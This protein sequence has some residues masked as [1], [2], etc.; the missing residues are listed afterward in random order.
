M[1][2]NNFILKVERINK[3]FG[4]THANKDIDLSFKRGEIMGLAGENGSGKSTLIS[5]IAG[6]YKQDSGKMF[7]NGESYEP[8]NIIDAYNRKIGLV[9]QEMGVLLHLP[10]NINIF[11]GREGLFI[12]KGFMNI[13]AMNKAIENLYSKWNITG[14]PSPNSIIG[15]YSV[16]IRKV[17]ELARA[18]SL[19]PDILVLDELS[20]SFSEDRR[21]NLYNIIRECKKENK[22][23]IFISHDLEELLEVTDKITVLRDGEVVTTLDTST[24]SED[25]LRMAMIGRVA[26]GDYYRSDQKVQFEEEVLMEVRGLNIKD[27]VK[28]ISFEL[29]KGEILALCGLSDSGVHDLGKGL[30]GLEK[31]TSGSVKIIKFN[32]E[33]TSPNEAIKYGV[34]YIPKDRDSEGIMGNARVLDNFCMPSLLELQGKLGFLNLANM[35]EYAE[36]GIKQFSVKVSDPLQLMLSLSGGNKQKVNLARWL[37]R[38]SD[39]LIMDC[40]TKG[41][42]VGIKEYIYELMEELKKEGK[43]ILLISD[44]LHEAIGMAD[45]IIVMKNGKINAM[46]NRDMPFSEESIVEV[47]V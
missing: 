4:L 36:N 7:V 8:D 43:A 13:R 28:D 6:I 47:M 11:L 5:I 23:I 10:I 2:D 44:E 17:L 38:D 22:A 24:S 25:D 16:E 33:I 15:N 21:K 31:K 41:V 29:H 26:K 46:Q 1:S 30:I 9:V 45:R 20:N 35:Y 14:M 37:V 18:L 42:D 12:N 34:A 32:K 27:K 19:D 3:Y 39:I 40:P